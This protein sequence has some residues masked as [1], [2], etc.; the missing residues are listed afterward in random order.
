MFHVTKSITKVW[1]HDVDSL[2]H[3]IFQTFS[4]KCMFGS[5][6][7][8]TTL[9]WGELSRHELHV[10]ELNAFKNF[11][12]LKTKV[13]FDDIEIEMNNTIMHMSTHF[14]AQIKSC[15]M[16]SMG[17]NKSSSLCG[18]GTNFRK[19]KRKAIAHWTHMEHRYRHFLIQKLFKP[20]LN[21]EECRWE[22]IRAESSILVNCQKLEQTRS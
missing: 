11:F 22:S 9:I 19:F 10:S 15:K 21:E 18:F 7:Q 1:H 3:V 16:A 8:M 20:G 5:E 17:Q 13:N 12:F 14:Y 6:S 2:Y 4:L